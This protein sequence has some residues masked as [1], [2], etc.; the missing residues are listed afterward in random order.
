MMLPGKQYGNFSQLSRHQLTVE[1]LDSNV[2]QVCYE[3]FENLL[4]TSSSAED[5]P[6][7][8]TT[9]LYITFDRGH[10]S[11]PAMDIF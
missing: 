5:F 2:Q 7:N 3:V 1:W 4:I 8:M 6:Y 11:S 10:H 9:I